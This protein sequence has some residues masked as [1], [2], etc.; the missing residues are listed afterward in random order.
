MSWKYGSLLKTKI[1]NK[2]KW[3]INEKV[4]I[5]LPKIN[6]KSKGFKR[7]NSS[8][9]VAYKQLAIKKKV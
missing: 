6:D 4:K 1:Q 8:Q 7:E 5:I 9:N 3:A 2:R